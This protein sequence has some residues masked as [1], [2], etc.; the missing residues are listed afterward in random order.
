[1]K[2]FRVQVHAAFDNVG[3]ATLQHSL[4]FVVRGGTV[5][6]LGITTGPEAKEA[7]SRVFGAKLNLVALK[8]ALL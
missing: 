2:S 4:D 1:M 6:T 7:D 5:V 8:A 3:P